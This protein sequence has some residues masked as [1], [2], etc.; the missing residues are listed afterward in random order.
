MP[1]ESASEPGPDAEMQRLETELALAQAEQ[2][3]LIE[4]ARRHWWRFGRS[5]GRHRKRS[6]DPA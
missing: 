5:S 3:R 6:S 1:S 4:T 2:A